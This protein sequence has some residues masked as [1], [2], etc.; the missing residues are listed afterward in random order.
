VFV[1]GIFKVMPVPVGA[2]Y[3]WEADGGDSGRGYVLFDAERLS[4]RPCAE[5]GTPI[6][7]VAVSGAELRLSGAG[8]PVD[9]LK[10]VRV[11]GAIMAKFRSTG[12]VPETA[13][14]YYG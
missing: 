6:S 14:K 12:E 3:R 2:V 9:R 7:D 10:L 8:T 13:H 1:L 4:V 11:A 5:D